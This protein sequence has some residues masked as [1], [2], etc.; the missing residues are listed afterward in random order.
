[1]DKIPINS[2]IVNSIQVESINNLKTRDVVFIDKGYFS[3]VLC[4]VATATIDYHVSDYLH[5]SNYTEKEV[6]LN[7]ST[8]EKFC[9]IS[10]SRDLSFHGDVQL[11]FDG[12]LSASDI[13]SYSC[14]L[15]AKDNPLQ[16]QIIMQ[17]AN[18]LERSNSLDGK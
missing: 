5:S 2:P 6:Y 1:M 3:L 8:G 17:Q 15:G 4:F 12:D 10:E 16:F 11:Y 14:S 9:K 13:K 7:S 18:I